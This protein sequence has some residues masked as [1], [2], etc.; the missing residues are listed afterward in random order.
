MLPNGAKVAINALQ[1]AIGDLG[2]IP[3][4]SNHIPPATKAVT[5]DQWR[6]YA[7]K[8][9]TSTSVDANPVSTQW[10]PPSIP[11]KQ[12]VQTVTRTRQ[13][14]AGFLANAGGP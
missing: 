14:T 3:P 4:A 6:T 12:S 1:E 8:R 10:K 13:W 11:G 7:Y 2:V 9:G 5:T